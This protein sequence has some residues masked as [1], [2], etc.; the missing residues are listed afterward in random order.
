[1]RTSACKFHRAANAM[2][3][4][5]M[6]HVTLALKTECDA[7]R[8]HGTLARHTSQEAALHVHPADVGPYSTI[9]WAICNSNCLKV[10]CSNGKLSRS[11]PGASVRRM[12]AARPFVANVFSQA[13][14]SMSHYIRLRGALRL[15]AT[16]CSDEERAF[17]VPYRGLVGGFQRDVSDVK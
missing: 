9:Y 1:M 5:H 16:L 17:A 7:C 2:P 3:V 11:V 6:A 12:S 10:F 13:H 4:G 15:C 14:G 8:T